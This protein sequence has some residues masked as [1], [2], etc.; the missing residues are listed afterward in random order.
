MSARNPGTGLDLGWISR[1]HVNQ[2]AVLRRAEQIQTRRTVKK[3]WQAAW[4][5]RA[6]TCIDLTTLS[7]DDTAS[8]VH[9]LCFKAKRPIREDLLRA[10]DVHDQGV[11]A[12]AVCVYPAR[13]RDAVKALGAAGCNIPVASVAT[14][15]PA[16]QTPLKTRL[17]EVRLAVEDGAAEVDVVIN[18]TLALTGQWEALYDEICQ[19]HE[20]CGE[21]HMKTILGTGDLG[22]LTNVYKASLVAMMAGSDFIK[23]S[24][25]KEAVNAIFPVALVMVRAIRD[26]HQKTGIKV[27]FKPAGGIR[28]AK[29]AL[30]WLSLMKEELGCEWLKPELF[31]L[32][33]SALL[34]DIERQLYH[35]V[36]GRYAAHHDLPMA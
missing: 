10:M 4:L 35:H 33:A 31:R 8:N 6:V 17:E 15:F 14:G 7:G 21:A 5:L 25:G 13:V 34:G 1:V 30:A 28:S 23:T 22:S 18:R 29:E 12:G 11:T 27:G 32:G 2:P 26:F 36:T 3:D 19:F 9:R 20:A 16:G 24:T